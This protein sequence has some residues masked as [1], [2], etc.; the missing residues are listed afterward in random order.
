MKANEKMGRNRFGFEN[1]AASLRDHRS[2]SRIPLGAKCHEEAPGM[3]GHGSE[4]RCR[5]G[6]LGNRLAG[7]AMVQFDVVTDLRRDMAG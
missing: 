4:S 5:E 7:R 2:E 6:G 1:E 3:A